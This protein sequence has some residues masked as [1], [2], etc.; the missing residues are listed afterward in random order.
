M[1]SECESQLTAREVC[2]WELCTGVS[3]AGRPFLKA[4]LKVRVPFRLKGKPIFA[5]TLV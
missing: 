2:E 1:L 5:S 3:V 4:N